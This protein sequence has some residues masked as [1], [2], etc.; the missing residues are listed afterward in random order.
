MGS[1]N[2]M[3]GTSVSFLLVRIFTQQL[4]EKAKFK[5][6]TPNWVE[7]HWYLSLHLET[8]QRA[9]LQP[10]LGASSEKL[11]N[12]AKMYN[13]Y[14]YLWL[15]TWVLKATF[16]LEAHSLCYSRFWSWYTNLVYH[17][18]KQKKLYNHCTTICLYHIVRLARSHILNF[19]YWNH[20]IPWKGYRGYNTFPL[21]QFL[22]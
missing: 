1:L 6:P 5:Q 7:M 12:G 16:R 3:T 15:C 10:W 17:S 2:A 8:P 4:L 20:T 11:G 21:S 9:Y 14:H 19:W 22:N 18:R 13:C